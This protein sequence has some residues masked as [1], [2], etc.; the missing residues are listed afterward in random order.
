[1][2]IGVGELPSALDA[3][4]VMCRNMMAGPTVIAADAKRNYEIIFA[5]KDSPDGEDYQSIPE[6]LLRTPQF[7][8]ALRQG[9]LEVTEG[10]DH[11]VVQR[12]MAR[13]T[14]AFR[15]KL[16]A[17]TLAARE[18]L[19]AASD[20]DLLV[21]NCIGPGSREGAVCGDQVAIKEKD[22]SGRP[23][24]CSRHQHLA[25]FCV[26]RGNNPWVLELEGLDLS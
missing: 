16:D 1:M 19:D 3:A 6:Y 21:V 15:K 5:G 26:K 23:P 8:K 18:V 13:Q 24:L 22:A 10:E 17:D 11:P 12:A 14:D 2:T 4:T 20:E 25:D 7:S 9:I